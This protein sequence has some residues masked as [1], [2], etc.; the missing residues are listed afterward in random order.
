MHRVEPVTAAVVDGQA[1]PAICDITRARSGLPTTDLDRRRAAPPVDPLRRSTAL[2]GPL[3]PT[4]D[5]FWKGSRSAERAV[6]ADARSM[7]SRAERSARRASVSRSAAAC[8]ACAAG[9]R[10]AS[11]SARKCF[12]SLSS[13]ASSP[14]SNHTPCGG[15]RSSAT[16]PSVTVCIAVPH[17]GHARMRVHRARLPRELDERRCALLEH[18]HE[19]LVL[20]PCAL[21]A[22]ARVRVTRPVR[23]RSC[24][25]WGSSCG[26]SMTSPRRRAACSA[27]P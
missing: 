1:R 9:P 5:F 16:E 20:D 21:A 17:S 2:T 15:Q 19:D 6:G 23:A 13:S 25:T 3:P 8:R 26:I 11:G 7:R 24:S 14:L 18:R 12:A 4:P 27:G 10:A 22:V